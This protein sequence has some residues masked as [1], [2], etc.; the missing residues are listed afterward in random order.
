MSEVKEGYGRVEEKSEAVKKN[1]EKYWKYK[2]ILEG[3]VNPLTFSQWNYDDGKDVPVGKVNRITWTEKEGQGSHGPI[4]YRNI[5]S[6]YKEEKD[7]NLGTDKELASQAPNETM[8]DVIHKEKVDVAKGGGVAPSS[9]YNQG[10]RIGMIYNNAVLLCIA[11]KKT[12]PEDIEEK[13]NMLL[14]LLNRLE[15]AARWRD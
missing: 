10:A 15:N 8:K 14:T 13:F 3:A 9:T 7:P 12:K 11:E 5:N 2:I 4:T 6:I 1:G